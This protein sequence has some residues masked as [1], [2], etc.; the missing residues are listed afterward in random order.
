MTYEE[1]TE[2]M[3]FQAMPNKDTPDNARGHFSGAGGY[4]MFNTLST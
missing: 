1:P 2:Q 4:G 3:T